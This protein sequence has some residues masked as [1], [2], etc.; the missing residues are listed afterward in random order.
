MC[1]RPH[2][3]PQTDAQERWT[4]DD[5][6]HELVGVTT[7]MLLIFLIVIIFA[8]S[9]NCKLRAPLTLV[10]LFHKESQHLG[11]GC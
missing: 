8:N 2:H 9:I 11:L 3:D 5:L 1:H 10:G 7:L 6:S 4:E